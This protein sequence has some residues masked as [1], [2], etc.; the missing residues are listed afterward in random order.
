MRIGAEQAQGVADER[1]E[2]L[3]VVDPRAYNAMRD[4]LPLHLATRDTL[5]SARRTV[6]EITSNRAS[7]H[8]YRRRRRDAHQ[9]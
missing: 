2:S 9:D 7:R 6:R 5:S 4:T 3:R 1:G 8:K